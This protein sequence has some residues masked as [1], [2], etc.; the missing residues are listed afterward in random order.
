MVST[1]FN[2]CSRLCITTILERNKIIVW[3][4]GFQSS[5]WYSKGCI[6]F[7]YKPRMRK[8]YGL[9]MSI[10]NISALKVHSNTLFYR[11]QTISGSWLMITNWFVADCSDSGKRL[12]ALFQTGS[13]SHDWSGVLCLA[14]AWARCA[15]WVIQICPGLNANKIQIPYDKQ[16]QVSSL[17]KSHQNTHNSV[18]Y[19]VI[20]KCQITPAIYELLSKQYFRSIL[21]ITG[22]SSVLPWFPTFG[23]TF[24]NTFV[25]KGIW[26]QCL[27]RQMKREKNNLTL[28]F[29]MHTESTMFTPKHWSALQDWNKSQVTHSRLSKKSSFSFL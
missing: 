20:W 27:S 15:I 18:K 25:R 10:V 7:C 8:W 16:H 13:H 24:W 2:P 3:E 21:D 23:G 17:V 9:G 26:C 14:W 22:E 5:Q 19:E 28:V 12:S 29:G 6:T 11:V 1:P 4:C